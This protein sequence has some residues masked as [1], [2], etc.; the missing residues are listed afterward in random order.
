MLKLEYDIGLET[1]KMVDTLVKNLIIN[2]EKQITINIGTRSDLH[3]T[4][5]VK[6]YSVELDQD[7]IN[8]PPHYIFKVFEEETTLNGLIEKIVTESDLPTGLHWEYHAF[9]APDNISFAPHNLR[10]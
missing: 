7:K 10:F 8:P 5:Y 2:P 1:I 4:K 3:N 6:Y 9:T